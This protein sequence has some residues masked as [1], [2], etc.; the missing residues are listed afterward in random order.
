MAIG[1]E[2]MLKM[3]ADWTDRIAQGELP[4][5]PTRPQGLERNVV[6]SQWDWADQKPTCT[7]WCQPIQKANGE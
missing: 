7:I 1:R 5:K 6:I 3:M 2:Q 4:S